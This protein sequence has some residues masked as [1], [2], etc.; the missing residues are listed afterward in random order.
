M[1]TRPHRSTLHLALLPIALVGVLAGCGWLFHRDLPRAM[2][3]LT[4]T[5]SARD[6]LGLA[7]VRKLHGRKLDIETGA[8]AIYGHGAVSV[9]M[10]GARDT[11]IARRLVAL[12]DERIAR[13]D[14]PFHFDGLHIVD[15][16]EVRELSGMGQRHY[17][18]RAGKRVV[19]IAANRKQSDEA[20]T[21]ALDFYR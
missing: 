15:G 7:E 20:L 18:F 21:E 4:P 6:D 19:W 2:V 14:T 17:C 1:P 10:A 8:L 13:G 11:V 5:F 3:G 12:M 16:R 9:W